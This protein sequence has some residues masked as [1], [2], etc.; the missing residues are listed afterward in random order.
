MQFYRDHTG[1]PKIKLSIKNFNSDL[2]I[3]LLH[4]FQI[5]LDSV[6]L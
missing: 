5:S 3:N 4:S 1:C 6:D 2:L